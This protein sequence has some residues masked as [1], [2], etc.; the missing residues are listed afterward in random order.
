MIDI[1]RGSVGSFHSRNQPYRQM[2]TILMQAN[3]T[4]NGTAQLAQINEPL[5]NNRINGGGADLY[6]PHLKPKIQNGNSSRSPRIFNEFR[7]RLDS[8]KSQS[9]DGRSSK[10]SPRRHY[11]ADRNLQSLHTPVLQKARFRHENK[12][13]YKMNVRDFVATSIKSD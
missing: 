7:S 8:A 9:S 13:V 2:P 11:T 12:L 3:R 5:G 4:F 6:L 1:D 10:G